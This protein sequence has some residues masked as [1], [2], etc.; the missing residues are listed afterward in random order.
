MR[1][2]L[3]VS[4]YENIYIN[5]Y[6]YMLEFIKQFFFTRMIINIYKYKYIYIYIYTYW[7][8]YI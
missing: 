8:V 3:Y 5:T 4:T 1:M 6:M 7:G 2:C